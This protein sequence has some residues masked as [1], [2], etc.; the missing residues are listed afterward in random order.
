MPEVRRPR[1]E[2]T[3]EIYDA[4][5]LSY[6]LA[7]RCVSVNFL[8]LRRGRDGETKCLRLTAC[9]DA[10]RRILNEACRRGIL[11]KNRRPPREEVLQQVKDK[12]GLICLLTEKIQ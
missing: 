5:T 8:N 3:G 6:V 10:A 1:E 7:R 12:D 4:A 11:G 9:F 2:K